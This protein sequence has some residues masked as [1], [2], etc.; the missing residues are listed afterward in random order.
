M[1]TRIRIWFDQLWNTLTTSKQKL[2]CREVFPNKFIPQSIS[3]LIKMVSA[4]KKKKK[5]KKKRIK[6]F[7]KKKNFYG[8]KWSCILLQYKIDTMLHFPIKLFFFPQKTQNK[9]F[10]KIILLNFQLL[11]CCNF[12]KKIKKING[13]FCN[14]TLKNNFWGP[15]LSKNPAAIFFEKKILSQF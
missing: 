13:S 8:L 12:M 4:K 7:Q 5:K 10:V 3:L 14:K 1:I 15:F 9:N 6:I 2:N 11:C